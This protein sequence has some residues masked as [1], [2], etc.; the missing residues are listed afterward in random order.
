M[1]ESRV[2]PHLHLSKVNKYCLLSG[3]PDRI[4]NIA[5]YLNGA[6]K[7]AENRGLVAFEG[8]TPRKGI[9]ISALTTGMGCPS[10]AIV[11]E[12][13]FRAG[14]EVFIR[15]GSCG[16]LQPGMRIG[17]VVIPFAAI[18]DER[19]SL[20]Y[21]SIEFPAV[22]S[23][24]IFQNLCESAKKLNF[25]YHAGIVWTTDVYYSSNQDS[26]KIWA[27][28]GANSVEM[29]SALLFVYGSVNKMR[30]GSILV[31]DGN[32]AEGTQK[33]EGILGDYNEIFQS[34]ERNA[35]LTAINT[36]EEID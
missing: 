22:S 9:P 33:D 29:E 3:N 28:C 10:S 7:V 30:T 21:A 15:I 31:I 36:I 4:T 1:T 16:A 2:Q 25:N 32:L 20:N 18:R 34:G 24:E 14:G 26:Y 6:K 8:R 35:I 13:A 12:E 17:E 27:K 5:N 23:P 11:L 19:T